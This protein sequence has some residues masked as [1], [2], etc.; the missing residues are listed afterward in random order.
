[1][2]KDP[3]FT[4]RLFLMLGDTLAII[5]AFT[6]A[7]LMRIHLDARP[8]YFDANPLDF[9]F[10]ILI[11]IPTW[12]II[13]ALLGLYNKSIFLATSKLPELYRLFSASIIGLMT[14]IAYGF[15]TKR[16]L[17]PTRTIAIFSAVL[18]FVMLKVVR[19][20]L[21]HIR[22][23]LLVYRKVGLQQ[24]V[25]VG[26]SQNT[27]RLLEYF[28]NTPEAGYR[29]VSVV[30]S[31]KYV[32]KGFLR[33]R[34]SS[35]KEA[36]HRL[37]A[38]PDIIF[39]TE[40]YQDE[41]V[42]TQCVQHHMLYYR[43]LS[44]SILAT[45][46]GDLK[47]IGDTPAVLVKIT[48]L[49]S[50]FTQFVKRT[51]DIVIGLPLFILALIP[52][53]LIWLIVKISEPDAPAFY[54]SIRLSRYNKK[55]KIYKFR[56]LKPAY[57]GLSPEEAFTKMGKPDLA[58]KYRA[59][60]DCLKNDPRITKLGHFLRSSSLDELPQLFNVL[61][62]DISLVGPRALVPGELRNY[63]DRSLLLS[64]KSGLTGLAQVSGRREL[65]FEERR[66][67]D[68][69]YV[70]NWSLKLDLEIILRTVGVVFTRKGAK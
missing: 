48:P 66:T 49:G 38:T 41:Y 26:N 9:T 51:S 1:M 19:T 50:G 23:L 34:D 15:F 69:Y 14:L 20:L 55:V 39:H 62:G 27:T 4:F 67:L 64:V 22:L 44:D 46:T 6:L 11:L 45:H 24:V 61:K 68:L 42:Y 25:V 2:K 18:C 54:G 47:L 53:A 59:N 12:W 3:S 33:L 29:V 65:S 32:P 28:K 56:T 21:R 37:H 60:G 57:S 58:K 36:F 63:G 10:S 8:F 5:S 16:E 70:Q 13:L 52:M 35:L 31:Q 43:I 40:S 17:F 7:Y 30:A